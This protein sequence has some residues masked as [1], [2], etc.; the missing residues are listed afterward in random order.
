MDKVR[1]P[2]VSESYTPSSESYSNYS[3]GRS[4][5]YL[6]ALSVSQ[7]MY[8][9]YRYS[10]LHGRECYESYLVSSDETN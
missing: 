5:I 9:L 4:A 1:K 8:R 2:N 3:V 7:T 6:T 10:K